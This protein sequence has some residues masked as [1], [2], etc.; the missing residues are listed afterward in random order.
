MANDKSTYQVQDVVR[1]LLYL[2][3]VVVALAL[4]TSIGL[5]VA[6]QGTVRNLFELPVQDLAIFATFF[7]TIVPFYQGAAT[8]M[9]RTYRASSQSGKKGE[10]LIDFFALSLE[11]VIFYAMGKSIY[12]L[13]SFVGWFGALLVLDIA[14]V[15]FTYF[16]SRNSIGE[17]PKLWIALNGGVA[18]ILIVLWEPALTGWAQTNVVLFAIAAVR[19]FLDYRLCYDFYFPHSA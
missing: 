13:A 14:W 7:L 16:K 5:L 8:Y 15:S 6:P 1:V 10:P 17:A 18:L 19:T 9:M 12:Q 11:A 2:Y 3:S 4:T